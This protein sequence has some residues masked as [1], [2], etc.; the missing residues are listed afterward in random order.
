MRK[1]SNLL[2]LLIGFGIVS[3]SGCS[4]AKDDAPEAKIPVITSITPDVTT[5]LNLEKELT[6]AV[7]VADEGV[8]TYQ[9]YV[10]ESKLSKGT[11]IENANS[12]SF[13]P[14]VTEVGTLYYY[15]II[16]NQ[17]GN[18]FRSVI[19]PLITFT[20]KEN[21]SAQSPIIIEQPTAQA[22]EIGKNFILNVAAYSSDNGVLTYQWYFTK[23]LNSTGGVF[24]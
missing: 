21:I 1:F 5:L 11:A 22:L 23:Q 8:L 24:L 10:A 4:F 2:I 19:S 16:N 14:P 17:L 6:V 18:S 3:L 20:V 9:W 13:I 15:C 7:D 12:Q